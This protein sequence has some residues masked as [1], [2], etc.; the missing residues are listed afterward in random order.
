MLNKKEK[1]VM[2][3]LFLKCKNKDSCLISPEEIDNYLMTNYEVTTQGV[4]Q[5]ING[6]VLDNYIDVV[7][8]DNKGKLIY[9]ISLKTK[10]QAYERDKISSKKRLFLVIFRTVILACVSFIVGLILK[11]LFS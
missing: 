11:A 10:G 7:H 6:L 8:S 4:D 2:D 1:K 9:C 3:F 5:I